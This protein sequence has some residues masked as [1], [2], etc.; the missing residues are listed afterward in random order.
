LQ[1]SFGKTFYNGKSIDNLKHA[2]F[3]CISIRACAESQ[4][5]QQNLICGNEGN[6]K[7]SLDGCPSANSVAGA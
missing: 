7:R 4:S 2:A 3:E 5:H 1:F 6:G